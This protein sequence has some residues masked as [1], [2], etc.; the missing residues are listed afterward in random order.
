MSTDNEKSHVRN[1]LIGVYTHAIPD[2]RPSLSL[3]RA[4]AALSNLSL[5]AKIGRIYLWLHNNFAFLRVF[6]PL[7][8]TII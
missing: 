8:R 1:V 7:R 6:A 5:P 3:G 2:I 4:C